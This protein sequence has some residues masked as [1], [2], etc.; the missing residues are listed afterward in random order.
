MRNY[1]IYL[2]RNGLTK[3]N[4]EGRYI[5]HTD[6]SLDPSETEKIKELVLKGRYPDA[7]V[8]IS[9]PLKRCLETANVIYPDN[10]PVILEDLIEYNFGEFEGKTAEELKDDDWFR[11]WLGGQRDAPPFGETNDGFIKRITDCFGKIVEGVMREGIRHTAIVTHGGVI[12][13]ILS[14]YALPSLPPTKWRMEPGCGYRLNLDASLW[15]RTG[16]IEVIDE[17]PYFESYDDYGY[18]DL[19]YDDEGNYDES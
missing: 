9:S 7:D 2:I 19:S 3:G 12:M 13:N 6:E 11:E 1:K 15:S 4:I 5:G 17:I 18:Y 16:G 10:N 14:C 8:I